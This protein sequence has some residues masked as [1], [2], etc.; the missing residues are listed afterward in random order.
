MTASD[1]L[2]PSIVT[3][4]PPDCWS[5]GWYTVPS[6]ADWHSG[7]TVAAACG[8]SSP[9]PDSLVAEGASGVWVAVAV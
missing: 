1:Q 9:L 5:K 4:Q 2:A 3:V 8:V 7:L 6:T